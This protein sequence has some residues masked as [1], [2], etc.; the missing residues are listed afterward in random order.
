MAENQPVIVEFERESAEVWNFNVGAAGL[1]GLKVD[2]TGYAKEELSNDHY[3]A[4]FLCCAALACFPN[5]FANALIRRG[6][7]VRGMTARAEIE[8]EKDEVFRTKFT[9]IH[10]E[11]TV[12]LDEKDRGIFEEAK[13]E[14]ETG[15]LV[16]YSLEDAIEMDITMRMSGD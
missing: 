9:V 15:S 13:K 16:T 12:D 2:R 11:V 6:A 4:R 8:K 3:G 1:P 14:M 5:T 10:L 7:Q